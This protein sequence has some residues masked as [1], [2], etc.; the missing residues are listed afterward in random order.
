MTDEVD[1]RQI[2][3]L[4]VHQPNINVNF[5]VYSQEDRE[6]IPFLHCIVKMFEVNS[7]FGTFGYGI[8]NI[9]K[10]VFEAPGVN[11]NAKDRR[12]GQT[13]IHY[14]LTLL[15]SI[16]PSIINIEVFKLFTQ[17]RGINWNI[18]DDDGKMPILQQNWR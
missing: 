6:I 11:F 1:R 13:L 4:L 14:C 12:L 3:D 5:E 18:P 2:F 15:S 9:Y 17:Y 7:R 10:K 8:N 16:K